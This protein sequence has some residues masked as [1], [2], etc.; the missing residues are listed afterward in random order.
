MAETQLTHSLYGLRIVV[1]PVPPPSL[2]RVRVHR[3]R[4]I[5][6]KWRKRYGFLAV[7]SYDPD[8]VLVVGNSV[9]VYPETKQALLDTVALVNARM[10]AK[11]A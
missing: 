8:E 3:R 2:V 7:R 11:Y 5:D 10:G 6:K 4:R 1:R 9:L